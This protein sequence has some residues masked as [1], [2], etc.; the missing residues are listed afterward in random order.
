MRVEVTNAATASGEGK[1][2]FRAIGYDEK[3]QEIGAEARL[4]L[5]TMYL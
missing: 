2:Y 4:L 3:G 1:P 5:I